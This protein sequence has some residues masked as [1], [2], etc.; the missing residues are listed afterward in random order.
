MSMLIFVTMA[1]VMFIMPVTMALFGG[2]HIVIMYEM[3]IILVDNDSFMS[4][5]MGTLADVSN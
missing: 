3:W 1:L 4:R 5:S 2:C